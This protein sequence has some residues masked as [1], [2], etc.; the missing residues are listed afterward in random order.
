MTLDFYTEEEDVRF[1][2]DAQLRL[3]HL[4]VRVLGGAAQWDAALT[5]RLTTLQRG[6]EALTPR[7]DAAS[8]WSE[9]IRRLLEDRPNGVPEPSELHPLAVLLERQPAV[10][11]RQET[12]ACQAIAALAF[13]SVARGA[14]L[15]QTFLAGLTQLFQSS[16]P[17]WERCRM[18]FSQTKKRLLDPEAPD[19]EVVKAFIRSVVALEEGGIYPPVLAATVFEN[20][21][22]RDAEQEAG[23]GEE[24]NGPPSPRP[25]AR[26]RQEPNFHLFE[27]QTVQQE[28]EP[29][30]SRFRLVNDWNSLLPGEHE[31]LCTTL[32]KHLRSQH[33]GKRVHAACRLLSMI[34][35]VSLEVLASAPFA[36]VRNPGKGAPWGSLHIDLEH[37]LVRRD[38][39]C[40]APRTDRDQ[41]RCHG[42]FM[43]TPLPPEIHLVL[44]EAHR[45]TQNARCVGDLLVAAE[46]NPT[47]CH[48]F[49]NE[50]R[51][52]PRAFDSLRIAR[53]LKNFFLR[54]GVHP[55]VI[56]H[57]LGDLTVT[58]RAHHYYLRLDQ[59]KVYE[60][61]NLWCEHIGLLPVPERKQYRS[62]GSPKS[63]SLEQL[64]LSIES[65]QRLVLRSRNAI[66]N[67]AT[68]GELVEFHNLYVCAVTLQILWG[69]GARC[70]KLA[71]VTCG[72]LLADPDLILL[73]DRASDRYSEWR[74]CVLTLAL[75]KSR[76]AYV[77][78]LRAMAARLERKGELGAAASLRSVYD[79][80]CSETGALPIL[81][82]ERELGLSLRAP[83]RAD[84]KKIAA[85]ANMKDLNCPRHFLISYLVSTDAAGVAI[86][87]QVGHHL[88]G[89]GAFGLS[90]GLT[91]QDLRLYL[92]PLL[93]KLHARLGMHPMLGLSSLQQERW[94]L[95]KVVLGTVVDLPRNTYLLQTLESLDFNPPDV[96]LAE[97]DCPWTEYTFAARGELM[98]LRAGY[99][100]SDA[101]ARW[102][103]AAS[104]FCLVAFDCVFSEHKLRRAWQSATKTPVELVG[105]LGV[106][107]LVSEPG[108]IEAQILLHEFTRHA[109]DLLAAKSVHH[110][111]EEEQSELQLLLSD[112][113][114]AWS[115][116]SAKAAMSRLL[117]IAAHS[118]HVETAPIARFGLVHKT[119]FIPVADMRRIGLGE[120][121]AIQALP[122]SKT[123][124]QPRSEGYSTH[125]KFLRF[126]A[127]TDR[128]CGEEQQRT[129]DCLLEL[130]ELERS[131]NGDYDQCL[132]I[133]LLRAE[134]MP[135]P[136]LRRLA[137]STLADYLTVQ[138]P[139]FR[140]VHIN[141]RLPIER[142]EW[143][144][145]LA[146]FS[147][148]RQENDC[149]V[150]S[151]EIKN[152]RTWAGQHLLAW[153][154][155]E[156]VPVPRGIL[157][158]RAGPRPNYRPHLHVYVTGR[159]LA[160]A[161]DRIGMPSGIPKDWLELLAK[162]KRWI[163]LRPLEARYLKTNHLSRSGEWALVTTSG[164]MHLKTTGSRGAVSVPAE[165]RQ[166]LRSHMRRR[167]N[168][169][170]AKKPSAFVAA[171]E[172]G[173]D[174]YDAS[175]VHLRD[176][177]RAVTGQEALRL[178]DLR[179]CALSDMV[180]SPEQ[181]IA[182]LAAS[183]P[184]TANIEPIAYRHERAAIAA[185]E[186]RHATV[187]T[188]LR[189]Y[190]LGG[191]LE[192]RIQINNCLDV[193]RP[194]GRYLAAAYG[195][196]RHVVYARRSRNI[197]LTKAHS[198]RHVTDQVSTEGAPRNARGNGVQLKPPPH[199][200]GGPE[201]VHAGLLLLA[202]V[203]VQ[204]AADRAG[205]EYGGLEHVCRYVNGQGVKRQLSPSVVKPGLLLAPTLQ[206][207]A[208]WAWRH[209][210]EL[211]SMQALGSGVRVRQGR[212]SVRSEHVLTEHHALWIDLKWA[213]FATIF[214]PA[215]GLAMSQRASVEGCAER[216]GITVLSRPVSRERWGRLAF[217][218]AAAASQQGNAVSNH[219]VGKSTQVVLHAVRL[220]TWCQKGESE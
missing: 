147:G 99:L 94:K 127:E 180:A 130:D 79:A 13:H 117:A 65:L 199:T 47:K 167:L 26:F 80:P 28:Q 149:P 135:E 138:T 120:R 16:Q 97:E 21:A 181:L 98:R 82:W 110:S 18:G 202:Q 217:I 160:E 146:V 6:F 137:F 196:T 3:L 176:E 64:K 189:Y 34:A 20:V 40:V 126:W 172:G 200:T 113:A 81:Y 39:F 37:G 106:I 53:A 133:R 52:Q 212:I 44:Q 2:A 32:V 213:G 186:A 129:V 175:L 45:N 109:I 57:T 156:G 195:V 162:L 218:P 211:Q 105:K 78:H 14:M 185:R 216:H 197:D 43:R 30:L 5:T 72:A 169:R 83:T 93:E 141:E 131:G 128:Q 75:K 101:L 63:I 46:L 179:A 161:L 157:G 124:R 8:H 166:E 104:L 158:D 148:P 7:F 22:L 25:P 182:R 121:A 73:T 71:S 12:V 86:D 31:E 112:I 23:E 58:P 33:E 96:L 163:P 89:A 164:H 56:S 87:A 114:P 10:T 19:R 143:E 62:L 220:A 38:F 203:P 178:Y 153:L 24:R 69:V 171:G 184:T 116:L 68:L 35:Q 67:R 11:N 140:W 170:E 92:E 77:E 134:L 150:E 49:S 192:A 118:L 103:G 122:G 95:P 165:M 209:R 115:E 88:P 177:L 152:R 136:P 59:R 210:E 132:V 145:A 36:R 61:M 108:K 208:E 76:L 17:H 174:S 155:F 190:H 70:Q 41:L 74:V 100:Q 66:T 191:A 54:R 188:S 1:D 204:A 198:Y 219:V 51:T 183:R 151:D 42:R 15:S 27:F 205:I 206:K 144:Q 214:F 194:S 111:W 85:L 48:G 50:G 142:E 102:P 201:A 207:V 107:E 125:V 215:V 139:F 29:T 193:L 119:P 159:E 168:A 9:G 123:T 84:L 60:A 187:L 154:E 4:V 173:Y 91:V 55:S 90:S